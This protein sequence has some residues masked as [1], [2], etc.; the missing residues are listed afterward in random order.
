MD[1][2]GRTSGVGARAVTTSMD[3]R[4]CIATNGQA[5]PPLN[6]NGGNA[7]LGGVVLFRLVKSKR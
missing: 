2:S 1:G 6:L 5:L 3:S 7:V 4:I